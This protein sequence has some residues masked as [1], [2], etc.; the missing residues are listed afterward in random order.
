MNILILGN[1]FIGYNL[2]IGLQESE[3]N[4]AVVDK[5][6]T[7]NQPFKLYRRNLKYDYDDIFEQQKPDVVFYLIDESALSRTDNTI[8]YFM[9]LEVINFL[10]FLQIAV[11]FNVKKVIILS[12]F[13]LTHENCATCNATH[14]Y[15]LQT[16]QPQFIN[17]FILELYMHYFKDT[18]KMNFVSLRT[19]NVYGYREQDT[20]S[21]N[22]IH[23]LLSNK[24]TTLNV[25]PSSYINLIYIGDVISALIYSLREDVTGIYNI[26]HNYVQYSILAETI[27]KISPAKIIFDATQPIIPKK[28]FSILNSLD[29]WKP[30]VS[31][32]TGI[33]V[34]KQNFRS[35]HGHSSN[36]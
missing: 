9:N 11:K 4:L 6:K 26:I 25:N 23:T 7:E 34:T 10:K 27:N 24:R 22:I 36:K 17:Q 28:H 18:Y 15:K 33:T 3:Y 20:W 30:I 8:N 16:L 31:L 2:A 5:R 13:D 21:N 12:S 19:S 29:N 14:K 32:E 1:G 35:Q